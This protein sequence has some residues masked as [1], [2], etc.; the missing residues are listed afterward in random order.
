MAT[1]FGCFPGAHQPASQPGGGGVPKPPSHT[2]A[3][4][5]GSTVTEGGVMTL[6]KILPTT[7]KISVEVY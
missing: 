5:R 6:R 7:G 2:A 1:Y 4:R 3:A